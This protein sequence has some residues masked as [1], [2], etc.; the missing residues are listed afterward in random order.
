MTDPVKDHSINFSTASSGKPMMCA[1][2]MLG[3]G[4]AR[5]ECRSG[6]SSSRS[7]RSR[8]HEPRT[9]GAIFCVR[10]T[11]SAELKRRR[12]SPWRGSSIS[13]RK[14]CSGGTC[15]TPSMPV[16]GVMSD[17]KASTSIRI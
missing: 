13:G 7:S 10:W 3:M 5:R 8:S 16:P 6:S 17:P 9:K 12:I 1:I 4:I 14:S 15:S 11:P 2:T